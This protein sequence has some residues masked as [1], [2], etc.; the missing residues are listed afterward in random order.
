MYSKEHLTTFFGFGLFVRTL[1]VNKSI[2]NRIWKIWSTALN[3]I[4][5]SC[6]AKETA[7]TWPGFVGVVL[8]SN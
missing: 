8:S 4:G 7:N 2:V 1:K 3:Q 5:S 6:K